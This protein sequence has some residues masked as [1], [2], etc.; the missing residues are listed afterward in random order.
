MNLL[1]NGWY[2]V[3]VVDDY[4]PYDMISKDLIFAGKNTKNIWPILL[5]KAWA[6]ING[7]YS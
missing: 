1:V 3:V 7:S 2:Q 4:I 5:E 6:K